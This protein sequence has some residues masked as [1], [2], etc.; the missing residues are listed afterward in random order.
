MN[1]RSGR[2]LFWGSATNEAQT[3][4][5]PLTSLVRK[6]CPK[7]VRPRRVAAKTAHCVV[8]SLAKASGIRVVSRLALRGF[9]SQRYDYSYA[10]TP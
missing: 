9:D 4:V 10:N 2:R 5:V 8:A 7:T 6:Q 1:G 3:M